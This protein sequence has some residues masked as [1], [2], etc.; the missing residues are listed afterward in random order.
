RWPKR[1][2]ADER[3]ARLAFRAPLY[4]ASNS[5]SPT[6]ELRWGDDVEILS[7][8]KRRTKVR[9]PDGDV[10]WVE[11]AHVAEVRRLSAR[12][13]APL[14]RNAQPT[15]KEEKIFDL[16][17]G[18]EVLVLEPPADGAPRVRVRARGWIGWLDAN[19]PL[20]GPPLLELYFIDVGQ[21]DGVLIRTPDGRHVLIDGGYTRRKNPTGKSAA[22]FVDWKFFEDYTRTRITLDAMIA[23]HCDAD[24][25]G[26]LWDLLRDDKQS[27]DE[28]D[29]TG[30]DVGAFYHAGVSWFE[31]GSGGR[32]LGPTKQR[33]LVRLLGDRA[34][35]LACL[36]K[37]ADPRLQGEWRQF[38]ERV[39]QAAPV[40][41]RLGVE[42]GQNG[43]VGDDEV[44][45]P[46]FGPEES[47]ATLQVLAPVVR[48]IDGQ[49]A[50]RSLD[51]A[52]DKNTNGHSILLRLRYGRARILLTGDLNKGSQQALLEAY[53]GREHVFAC[54]V[55]KACHHG[56]EDVSYCFLKHMAP[57]ATIISSGDAEGHAHPRPAIIAAS[58]L[59]GHV[60]MEKDELLTPLVYATEIERSVGIGF[61]TRIETK[62]YPHGNSE[63]ELCIYARD[64][65]KL[66]QAFR[67]DAQAKKNARSV[68]FYEETPAGALRPQSRERS[69][70]NLA[71][72]S[73]IIYGLVNVR[74]DGKTIL[75]A[76]RNESK[77]GWNV[78]TFESRF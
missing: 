15:P 50:V 71:I 35:V 47:D 33:H 69:F 13:V 26:G 42:A 22:D 46:G 36:P 31:R 29:A 2:G 45:V 24:H 63:I 72:V 14:W 54:D 17:W 4:R 10:G 9:T 56:S 18:D 55:A 16:L 7:R 73:G 51:S 65:E 30:C 52:P 28:L 75:C 68:V 21:G 40:I 67:K 1:R 6:G 38:L 43:V 49:P 58:G 66:P 3:A 34:D 19:V 74:T 70:R 37:G 11:H 12:Y 27:V 32:W 20:D 53:K 39:V 41:E 44:Y 8:G 23:S 61:V 78:K 57:A 48:N 64:A 76:T 59:T 5:A 60:T 25:Y 77:N 62:K